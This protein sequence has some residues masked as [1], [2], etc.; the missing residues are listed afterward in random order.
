MKFPVFEKIVNHLQSQTTKEIKAFELGLDM[1]DWSDGY[2]SPITLLLRAYYG[3]DGE[4]WVSWFIYERIGF[5]DSPSGEID[6]ERLAECP[7]VEALWNK[8]E[9][10]RCSIEYKEYDLSDDAPKRGEFDSAL[11]MAKFF[12]GLG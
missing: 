3:K 4:D 11:L 1:L 2:I 6:A 7:T 5:N 10:L 8:V 9:T 12:G